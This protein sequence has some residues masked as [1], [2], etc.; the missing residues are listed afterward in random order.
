M[1]VQKNGL[2]LIG[3]IS[4]SY[5]IIFLL[6]PQDAIDYTIVDTEYLRKTENRLL[7]KTVYN[8]NDKD[9][10]AS[11]PRTIGEWKSFNYRYPESVYAKSSAE[12]LMSRGYKKYG[13][14]VIWMDIMNSKTGEA[15][16]NQK[17]CIKGSGW[18]I[19]NDSIVE[20][21]IADFPNPFKKLYANMLY[22]SKKDKKQVII[23]WFMF[24]ELGSDNSVAMIRLSAPVKND[25]DETFNLM[26]D[27]VENQLFDAMYDG[28]ES[29]DVTM[30]EYVL[31]TYGNKG[32]LVV[33][34][35]LLMPIGMIATGIRKKN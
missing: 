20:F 12:I 18:N 19:D 2:I 32:L 5:I 13:G 31:K 4:L 6:A 10:V 30:L 9:N 1:A 22:V 29:E 14:N 26:R 23:Y 16:H 11:F 27:F 35:I 33:V 15:I 21:K 17:L 3:I 25:T 7:T 28:I 24:K 8:Y 34:I